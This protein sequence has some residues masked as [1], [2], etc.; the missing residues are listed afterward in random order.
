LS[1]IVDSHNHLSPD[2]KTRHGAQSPSDLI[3]KMDNAGIDIAIIFGGW[4][5]TIEDLRVCNDFIIN[6]FNDRTDRFIPFMCL[7]P[8]FEEKAIEELYRCV[9]LGGFKGI[10][11]HPDSMVFPAN[12]SAMLPIMEK[13]EE[14]DLVLGV[15]SSFGIYAH[16]A[17]IGDLADDFP[18]VNVILQHM[19]GTTNIARELQSIKVAKQYPNLF[20]ETSFSNPYPIKKAVEAVGANRILYG[21]DTGGKGTEYESPHYFLEIQLD[22]VRVL[23][24]PKE[25]EEMILGKN[26]LRLLGM[27][28]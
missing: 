6:C 13:A 20:L 9:N 14:N 7:N 5:N 8:R 19:G 27:E 11:I 2:W 18:K 24:L 21:S 28:C 26:V 23:E 25:E 1:K 15:H 17:L 16:P 22:A 4:G 10:K 12:T 3:D